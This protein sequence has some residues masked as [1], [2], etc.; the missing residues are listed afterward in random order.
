MAPQQHLTLLKKQHL[1]LLSCGK[2]EEK[3]HHQSPFYPSLP[4][5]ELDQ[6]VLTKDIEHWIEVV[7]FFSSLDL[8][9]C[10]F[11][12][13]LWCPAH[14]HWI[15]LLSGAIFTCFLLLLSSTADLHLSFLFWFNLGFFPP[16]SFCPPT[17]LGGK[18]FFPRS[19]KGETVGGWHSMG[20]GGGLSGLHN[21]EKLQ[22]EP[23]QNPHA[24]GR[25][26]PNSLEPYI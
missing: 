23:W 25:E 4:P 24:Q 1:S 9:W 7:L 20:G 5:S 17:S 16:T 14:F 10:C 13:F 22:P 2:K 18:I 11:Y 8:L 12:S 6:A 15:F 19:K 3:S 21:V 26:T